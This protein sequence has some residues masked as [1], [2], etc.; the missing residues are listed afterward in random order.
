MSNK[1]EDKGMRSSNIGMQGTSDLNV[2]SVLPGSNTYRNR[3]F[4]YRGPDFYNRNPGVH[5][6]PIYGNLYGHHRGKGPKNYKRSDERIYENINDVLT[7]DPDI[8]ASEIEIE[9]QDGEVKLSGMVNERL[10]KRKA[11]DLIEDILGVTNVENNIHVAR[12]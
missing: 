7:E 3:D 11:E 4:D 9:V 2:N 10:Q 12:F 5:S 1:I 8:D 6:S